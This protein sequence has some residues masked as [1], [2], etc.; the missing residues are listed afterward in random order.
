MI[1]DVVFVNVNNMIFFLLDFLKML[2]G[3]K[4]IR[5]IDDLRVRN[6]LPWRKCAE[7]MTSAN[8]I[9]RRCNICSI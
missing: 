9:G 2:L 3:F 4:Q 5:I 6:W 8:R 7:K 1:A